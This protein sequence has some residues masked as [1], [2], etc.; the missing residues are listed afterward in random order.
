MSCQWFAFR[1]LHPQVWYSPRNDIRASTVLP[2][3]LSHSEPR[4][5]VDDTHTNSNY[6]ADGSTLFYDLRW[7]NLETQRLTNKAV[8]AYESFNCLGS[9]QERN[10]DG[11]VV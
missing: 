8:T 9:G 7:Q 5:Y 11:S 6:D 3:C 4:M 10:P 1:T 2:N